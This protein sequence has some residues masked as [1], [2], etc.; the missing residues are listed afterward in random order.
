MK[1]KRW[2][3]LVGKDAEFTDQAVREDPESAYELKFYERLAEQ[4]QW[5]NIDDTN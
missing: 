4:N 2:R 5:I 3:I 1:E